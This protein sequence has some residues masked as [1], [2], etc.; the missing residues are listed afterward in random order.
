MGENI[1]KNVKLNN[2]IANE[3]IANENISELENI[4]KENIRTVK[5]KNDDSKKSKC[6]INEYNIEMFHSGNHFECYKFMGAHLITEERKRGVRFTTWA[7]NAKNVFV[8]GDFSNFKVEEKYKMERVSEYGLYSIFIPSIK[9]GTKY[10]Y[11][12]ETSYGQY[13]YKA[14]PYAFKSEVRPNTA[15]IVSEKSKHK[16]DDRSW[17]M[18]RRYFNMY[19]KPINVYE[20][21]LGSWKMYGDK[22]LTYRELAEQLPQYLSEMGYT[23]IEILPIVEHPLDASWGYQGVG[24]YSVT[25]RY[26]TPDDFKYLINSFHKE[27]IGVILDWVPGH[28]CKDSH[29]LYMF[30]GTPT[31]EY[32]AGWKGEN[33]GWGT[34][35]FDLGRN[36]VKS[37]LISNALYWIKEFH[38]D[39][40]RVD[41]VTNML[42]LNYDRK[43]GEWEPNIYGGDGNLE[44]IE[45][46]KLFNTIIDKEYPTV[47]TIA[48]ESTAWPKIS[49]P[50]EE[51]GLGFKFKWNMGWMHDTL[52]YVKEDPINRKYHH[53]KMTFSMA[54]HYTENFILSISHDEVVH[55]KGS[56]VNKMW[57]DYWNKFAG[58]RLY[59][60]HMIAHPGKKLTFMGTEFAQFA[61][62]QEYKSLDWHLLEQFE[63]HQKINKYCKELNKYY[64]ENKSLWEL[65]Y[66]SS[67]FQWISADNY[68]DSIFSFIRKGKNKR[69]ISIVVCN[70]TPVVR[71]DHRIGV[72][73]LESYIESFNSDKIE[74][75]GSG[76]IIDTDLVAEEKPW[77]NQPYSISIKVP[78]MAAI[79]LKLKDK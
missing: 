65:D 73:F 64:K 44:A 11:T 58:L 17:I 4:N 60:A 39:G 52:K 77:N 68:A 45:F 19:E 41:A 20:A 55:L 78:P 70:Y 36:E 59:M 8:V 42:Y 25:S 43:Y 12:I 2:N 66:D 67:G 47:M 26:G 69:E 32:A 79:I 57:G 37:F 14:D 24:Y 49:K 75:G 51:G 21:H 27:G 71:Y 56:L 3:N 18:K 15:S 29:G 50:I 40:L 46:I 48:E 23:H 62:W 16:W 7:P 35:N 54:Y 10:K 9:S 63:M 31:Y 34:N 38:I 74:F 30:D 28:F 76:Q 22:S 5:V 61:E 33:K 72:P 53:D 6:E 1:L 13:I